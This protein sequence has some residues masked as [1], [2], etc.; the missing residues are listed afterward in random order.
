MNTNSEF[1]HV[2]Q[3]SLISWMPLNR[4]LTSQQIMKTQY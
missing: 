2:T 1:T 3:F 4:E